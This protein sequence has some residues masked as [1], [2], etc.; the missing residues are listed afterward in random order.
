MAKRVKIAPV[1]EKNYFTG[2]KAGLEFIS[3]GC[4]VLDCALGG[5]WPLGRMANIVGDKSTAKTALATE[6]LINFKRR[7]PNGAAAY[8]ECEAAYDKGYAE[9]MGLPVNEIDFGD[10][11][12]PLNTV[13]DF[14]RDLDIF[15]EQQQ[16]ANKPGIYVLDSLDSLSDAAEMGRDIGDATY[17]G[18]KAKQ[19]S[20]LFRTRVRAVE[21]SRVLLLIVS[22]VR[23]NIGAMFGEKH[24]RSGGKAMDFYASLVLW[25]AH[26]KTLK[27]TVNKVERPIGVTI[28]AKVKKNKISLPFRECDFDFLFG[29]GVDDIGAGVNWLAEVGRLDEMELKQAE[30]KEYF[31]GLTKVSDQEYG[32]EQAKMYAA[33]KKVW[34]EIEETFLPTR[35][36]YA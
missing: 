30:L 12:N 8:R 6:A 28:R 24:K 22:Q 32:H 17:G 36:K 2:P 19:L 9:A 29:Y 15:V 10:E 31:K 5:G 13:E 23:D 7:Y 26:I 3:S 18:S 25:L 1:K 14:A 35:R 16:K 21:R 20:V 11:D 27:K 34:P 33:V 4:T